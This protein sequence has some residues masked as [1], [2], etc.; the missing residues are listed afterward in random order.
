MREDSGVPFWH[1]RLVAYRLTGKEGDDARR[2][3]SAL[4]IAAAGLAAL[5]GKLSRR[6]FIRR[7]GAQPPPPPY[8]RA[9]PRGFGPRVR[10]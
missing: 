8:S 5:Q 7:D 4:L 3:L 10:R 6:P 9:S 1:K 2:A